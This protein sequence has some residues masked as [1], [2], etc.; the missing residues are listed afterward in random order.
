MSNDQKRIAIRFSHEQSKDVGFVPFLLLLLLIGYSGNIPNT[1]EY[2]QITWTIKYARL[3]IK[4]E[5]HGKMVR[6]KWKRKEKK[7]ETPKR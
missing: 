2:K 1:F 4:R 6:I 5:N 3:S 7:T